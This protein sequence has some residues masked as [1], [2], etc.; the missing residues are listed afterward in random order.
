MIAAGI[1]GPTILHIG[2]DENKREWLPR[3][4]SGEISMWLGYSEPNAGSD[5]ASIQTTAIE[6]GDEYV[7]NGQKVWSGEAH[8]A[9]F[10]WLIAR[11]DRDAPKH[12]GIFKGTALSS[13]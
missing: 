12:K 6:D 2:T 10:A 1:V 4:A 5:L 13:L 3:I 7:I 9:N 8:R 11:T